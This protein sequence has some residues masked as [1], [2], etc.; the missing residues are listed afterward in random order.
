M[1]ISA[2]NATPMMAQYLEIKKQH[3]DCLLFYRMG[4]FYELFFDDAVKASKALDI[5]LTKRG[6]HKGSDIPMCGVPWHA[7]ESYLAKLIKAGFKVAICEQTEDP[8]EA[9][10]RGSKSVVKRE[11]IRIV[12]SGTLTEEMLLDAKSNNYLAAIGSYFET[13]AMAWID[14]STGEFYTQDITS[15]LANVLEKLSP[16]EILIDEKVFEKPGILETLGVWKKKMTPLPSPRFHYENAKE[17][18][19]AFFKTKALETLGNFNPAQIIAAGTI[20]DYI[21]LTQKGKVPTLKPLTVISSQKVMEI[22]AATRRNLEMTQTLSG[23]KKKGTLLDAIDRTITNSGARLLHQYLNAPLCDLEEILHRQN[24]IEFFTEQPSLRASLREILKHLPDLERALSRISFHRAGPRDLDALKK[25]LFLIPKIKG[26]LNI[27]KGIAFDKEISLLNQS[28][29]PFSSLAE[30]LSQALADE[31]PFLA[32][33]GGFIAADFH[34]KLDEFRELKAHGRRHILDLQQ[35]Y[36]QAT[37]LPILKIKHNNLIGYHIEIP[38]AKA[39]HLLTPESGFIHRQTMANAVRFTTPELAE[40]ENN[41]RNATEKTLVLELEIFD[42][43]CDEILTHAEKILQT[44]QSLAELDVFSSLAE[45]AET[46][47][48]CRPLLDQTLCFHIQN[49]RHPVVEKALKQ[50]DASHAF[51]ANTC[52]LKSDQEHKA[53]LW[54]LTGPN[55]AGKST[56]LR[57]NALIAILA[58]IGSFVP[59]EK[60]HIGLIDKIFSRVGAADDLA[61]GRSTLWLKW[62]KQPRF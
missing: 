18:L 53:H 51:M 29:F 31:L 50:T 27:E 24:S 43:L 3:P 23:Q 34:P 45:L 44:A 54:L 4:D 61:S 41:L 47:K 60:A 22:D 26:L 52:H 36:I 12:T 42:Q 33:D 7:H 17:R 13:H 59:A 48:Y 15:S 55:M 30:K 14:V 11:V 5:A 25:A 49:G 35:Q 58:H 9:K 8:I 39:T 20:L 16:S 40:M 57:Q 19:E 10:K 2:E 28:L 56:F 6:Q 32:R 37:N 62:L 21:Q 46:E 1:N 38:A